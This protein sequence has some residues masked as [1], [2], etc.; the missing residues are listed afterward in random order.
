MFDK[1][2]AKHKEAKKSVH[3]VT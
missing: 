1:Q 3:F 2:C